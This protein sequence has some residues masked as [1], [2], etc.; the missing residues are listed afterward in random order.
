MRTLLPVMSVSVV[1]SAAVWSA[2]GGPQPVPVAASAPRPAGP[3]PSAPAK[4]S[5]AKRHPPAPTLEQAWEPWSAY[6]GP[7][8]P[9]DVTAVDRGTL[10]GKV[11]A[12]YQGWF[13]CADDGA[14]RGW[15]HYTKHPTFEPGRCSI[16]VWPDVSE[17][18]PDE[19]HDTPFRH[20][21]GSVARVFS[22]H[23]RRTVLRHFAWMRAYG[24]D[25][26]FVQR[27]ATDA[28]DPRALRHMNT[29]LASC[30]EG[31]VREGRVWAVMYDLT[32]L[33]EG[34]T[35]RVIDDWRRLVAKGKLTRDPADT[36]YLH[37]RG[38]P[39]VALWGVGFGD[40]RKYT[41]AECRRLVEF[42][43]SDPETGGCGV[44]LGVPY[45]WRTLDRDAAKD[46]DL[47]AVLKLADVVSPWTIGRV[48]SIDTVGR[49]AARRWKADIAWCREAGVDY[50]PVA[51]PGFSWHNMN[52]EHPSDRIP[53][54]KGRFLWSQFAG[55]KAAGA[56]AIYVAMFDEMDEA[57]AIFKCTDNPPSG[58]G[59]GTSRFLTMEGLPS[60]HYLWLTGQAGRMLRGELPAT[61]EPPMRD[62]KP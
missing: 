20:A 57:T 58:A 31:A 15:R 17:L 50:L 3:A 46:P 12:G 55:M 21:D 7:V 27:F 53:R 37:H 9:K 2:T 23:D 41:L 45:G 22:S 1:L 6:D 42:F 29:V 60:D 28:G 59:A 26:V 16:D 18:A 14:G 44:M 24:I 13:N 40:D 52:P 56:A 33:R 38:K 62:R 39:L 47:H 34:G 25:G 4:P 5:V 35:Q 32:G 61:A 30:R 51:Y 19:L 54:L 11:V 10:T 48:D 8:K 49:E 36:A 43:R